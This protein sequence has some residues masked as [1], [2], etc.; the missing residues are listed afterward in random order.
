LQEVATAG[1]RTRLIRL[2]RPPE[3]LQRQLGCADVIPADFDL[4]RDRLAAAGF[5]AVTK[6]LDG[7]EYAIIPVEAPDLQ[8][9]L[10][11]PSIRIT[12]LMG[13]SPAD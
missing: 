2:C 8:V 6:S 12:E 5:D 10:Y 7:Q 4:A 9:S 13:L 11:V 3:G 1:L